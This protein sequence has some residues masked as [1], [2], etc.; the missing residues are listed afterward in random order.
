MGWCVEMHFMQGLVDH[1]HKDG[2]PAATHNTW[3]LEA[4]YMEAYFLL[5]PQSNPNFPS[6]ELSSFHLLGLPSP[7]PWTPVCLAGG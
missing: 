3:F 6:W 7:S 4:H 2:F 1:I 5:T